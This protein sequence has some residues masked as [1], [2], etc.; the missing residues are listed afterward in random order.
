MAAPS[1]LVDG[2]PRVARGYRSLLA[3]VIPSRFPDASLPAVCP[4]F[5]REAVGA[6]R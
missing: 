1:T 2:D 3:E 5:Q 6:M 4:G